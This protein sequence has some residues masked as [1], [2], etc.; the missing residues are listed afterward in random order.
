MTCECVVASVYVIETDKLRWNLEIV[1]RKA[2]EKE[3]SYLRNLICRNPAKTI[4]VA[5][6]TVARLCNSQ[7]NCAANAQYSLG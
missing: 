3:V 2:I 7:N 4:E 6:N 5:E 1:Y